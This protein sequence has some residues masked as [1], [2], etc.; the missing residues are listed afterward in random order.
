MKR[1]TFE[2][3]HLGTPIV[4]QLIV[5]G[6]DFEAESSASQMARLCFDECERI[7]KT[8]SRFLEDTALAE[9]NAQVGEWARVEEEFYRLLEF[10]EHLRE[11]T[12]GAFDLSVKGILESWSYDKSYSFEAGESGGL[13][14]AGRMELRTT[15][16][17]GF[18]V[19]LSV[20]VELGGLGKGYAI[21][22]MVNELSGHC[23][24]LRNLRGFCI[25]AG[26]DLFVQGSDENGEPWRILFEHPTDTSLAIGEV[27]L[28]GPLALAASSP[29]RRHWKNGEKIRHHLVDPR[30]GE[31]AQN[32]LAVYIQAPAALLADAYSTALFVLGFEEAKMLVPQLPL[33]AMLIGAEGQ[34]WKS[35]G[36]KG[37][38]FTE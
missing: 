17:E 27:R 31:P 26:G 19:R 11:R 21:D 32:M 23:G 6:E 15:L 30:T 12:S 22:R 3:R 38:L 4:L 20:P 7:E 13:G 5:E 18:E 37:E 28:Y 33:E 29:S 36:F 34:F 9:L 1:F 2:E 24:E 25:N 10:G 14:A 35:E 16:D 8:Y